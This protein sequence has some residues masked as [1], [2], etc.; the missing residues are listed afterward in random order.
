MKF[1]K[2]PKN[3]EQEHWAYLVIGYYNGKAIVKDEVERL[4]FI[5]CEE[6][7]APIGTMVT[8]DLP[9]S[10]EKLSAEEQENI[11]KIYGD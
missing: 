8:E 3:F 7:H 2:E 11:Q 6:E 5:R 4:Y 9:E 10:I 1:I